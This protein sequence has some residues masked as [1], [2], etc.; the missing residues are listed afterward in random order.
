MV[1]ITDERGR[2]ANRLIQFAHFAASGM[3]HGF[4]VVNYNFAPFADAFEGTAREGAGDPH[5][6]VFLARGE[7]GHR[8]RVQGL[9]AAH[10][11]ARRGLAFAGRVCDVRRSHDATGR[12]FDLRDPEFV[13]A[14]V[15][16]RV[17]V[18]G[19]LFRDYASVA[20]HA[21]RI[22]RLFT[23]VAGRRARVDALF[24]AL[25]HGPGRL[26]IGLHARRGDYRNFEGGRYFYSDA[27]YAG[28]LERT[29]AAFAGREIT[30]VVCSDEPFRPDA[31]PRPHVTGPGQA[32][33]DL[34][35]LSRCDYVVGPPSTFTIW[36]SFFGRAPLLH[37]TTA[38]AVIES[39]RFAVSPL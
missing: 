12:Q 33:E 5:A 25:P 11:A 20:A 15:R 17:F 1:I 4:P 27:E 18:E 7:M 28:I 2:L 24:G 32:V 14:A 3:E 38:D 19:W 29:A 39:S 30:F 36:A 16:G 22:R 34:Y 9:R 26:R 8:L 37:V 23:P 21:D 31:L 35:A 10:S 13:A 6:R